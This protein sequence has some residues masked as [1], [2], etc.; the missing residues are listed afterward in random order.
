[1]YKRPSTRER[2]AAELEYVSTLCKIEGPPT[3]S[4]FYWVANNYNLNGCSLYIVPSDKCK[5]ILW[6]VDLGPQDD[7]WD[8]ITDYIAQRGLELNGK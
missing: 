2:Y 5:D 4:G 1:M 3:E 8:C 6:H 7:W